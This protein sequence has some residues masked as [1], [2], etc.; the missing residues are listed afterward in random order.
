MIKDFRIL[1]PVFREVGLKQ[2]YQKLNPAELKRGIDRK[3]HLIFKAYEEKNRGRQASPSKK[4][5]P[6]RVRFYVTQQDPIGL[7]R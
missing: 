2:L 5:T 6:R 7:G 1:T 4:Q 3:I